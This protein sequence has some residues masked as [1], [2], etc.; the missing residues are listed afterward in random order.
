MQ[1]GRGGLIQ[2]PS[3]LFAGD[4]AFTEWFKGQLED[5]KLAWDQADWKTVASLSF[6]FG[7]SL[8]VMGLASSRVGAPMAIL[9]GAASV[10]LN[11]TFNAWLY[12]DWGNFWA[13]LAGSSV[14]MAFS[15]AGGLIGGPQGWIIGNVLGSAAGQITT[16]VLSGQQW[17]RGL[18]TAMLFSVVSEGVGGAIGHGLGKWLGG[19]LD[20]AESHI[21]NS[22]RTFSPEME[23][24]LEILE[25]HKPDYA[26]LIR[27]GT[28]PLEE[29]PRVGVS[30]GISLS[31]RIIVSTDPKYPLSTA[32]TL[33]EEIY[34]TFQGPGPEQ[35][36]EL[37]AKAAKAKWVSEVAD[38]TGL[39][40]NRFPGVS[41]DILAFEQGGIE[42]LTKWLASEYGRNPKAAG[43]LYGKGLNDDIIE[44]YGFRGTGK[45]AEEFIETDPLI[46][47][48]HIGISF[49]RGK[50]IYG[51]TP[52]AP[53][54]S[55]TEAIEVLKQHQ[56]FPGQ[57]LDDTSLFHRAQNLAE[58]GY[59]TQVYVQSISVSKADFARIKEQVLN[60]LSSGPL[61]N[62]R[63]AF[64]GP[65]GCFNC[66]TWPSSHGIPIPE[67]SGNLRLYIEELQKVGQ[68]WKR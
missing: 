59:R 26:E 12:D 49:D 28:I 63:Y 5:I 33:Y 48:G 23:A 42:G 13:N 11:T 58:Q 32:A 47:A 31:D 9:A 2:S 24:G 30:G 41:G 51:F 40:F 18:L 22:R 15:L 66:A 57:V 27:N 19:G 62:K 34:H 64:P 17:D 45:T 6:G 53:G 16:N 8:V 21:S 39:E 43:M 10:V 4:D 3:D 37:E 36:I 14:E 25:Q 52:F 7:T 1:L 44:I 55:N 60:E 46:Y 29:G 35:V 65:E 54:L 68:L 61:P 38:K 56:S 50:T 20:V 67:S